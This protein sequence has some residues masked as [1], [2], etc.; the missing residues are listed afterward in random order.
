[1]ER[2]EHETGQNFHKCSEWNL[3]QNS[4]VQM[5]GFVLSVAVVGC[6]GIDY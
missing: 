6:I 1:M 4:G 3:R 2:V 5:G